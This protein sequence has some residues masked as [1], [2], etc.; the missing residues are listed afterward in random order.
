MICRGL[1]L[2]L[3][4]AGC[5]TLPAPRQVSPNNIVRRGKPPPM[6][7]DTSPVRASLKDVRPLD[8]RQ[9]RGSASEEKLFGR[10]IEQ[11]HYLGYTRPV[12]E[13]LKYLVLSK[14]RPLACL[15][16]SSAPRHLGPRDR[17]I[18]WS[19]QARRMNIRFVAY[20]QRFLIPPWVEV[21]YLAS[22]VLSRVARM[23]PDE[24]SRLYGHPVHFLETFVDCEKFKGTC[25]R[26][27][28]WLLCLEF[29]FSLGNISAKNFVC[30]ELAT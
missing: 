6:A 3:H 25:Y 13:H 5:I 23:L 19:A 9:V 26:A 14:G 12:G 16:F 24:W 8:F 11:Y 4:R 20:N 21:R 27:A 10:L 29:L 28:N 18:G 7:L 17:F 1:M 22:H 30:A 15:A 2:T